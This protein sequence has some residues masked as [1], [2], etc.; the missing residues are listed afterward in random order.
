MNPTDYLSQWLKRYLKN[1]DIVFHK[2]QTIEEKEGFV[3]VEEK[4]KKIVYYIEPFI[5]SLK[6]LLLKLESDST[7]HKGLVFYNTTPN[8]KELLKHWDEISKIKNLVVYFVNP[9]SRLEKKWMLFPKT[10]ALISGDDVHEG[11]NSLFLTVEET[12]EDEL[13]KIITE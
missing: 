7:E 2:I 6:E 8:F 10:H 9:F 1:R 5:K 3:L 4:T 12:T 13:T 11:L